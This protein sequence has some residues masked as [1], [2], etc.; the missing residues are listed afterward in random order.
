MNYLVPPEGAPASIAPTL[1]WNK[2]G[3]GTSKDKFGGLSSADQSAPE[4]EAGNPTVVP[5]NLLSQFLFTFL[6]RHPSYSVPSYYRCTLPPLDDTTGFH[7][8]MPSETGISE[9]RRVF[10]YL[11]SIGNIG[12]MIATQDIIDG[13]TV[14]DAR[15]EN[16]NSAVEICVVD[17]DDLLDDPSGIIKAY[18]DSVGLNFDPNNLSWDTEEEQT[19]ARAAFEKWKGFHEDAINSNG[20]TPR[21]H[22][23]LQS[24]W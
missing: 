7:E 1:A 23:S 9:L 24:Q 6:I 22:V 11:R 20:L 17:A 18:C 8:F 15:A 14:Q 16:V 19:K 13:N 21:A 4:D 5:R 10:D 12:P 3:V 2:R